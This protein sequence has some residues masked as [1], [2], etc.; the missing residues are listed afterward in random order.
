LAEKMMWKYFF[1]RK[2]FSDKSELVDD[3]DVNGVGDCWLPLWLQQLWS[4]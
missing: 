1:G 4:R 3:G 2:T